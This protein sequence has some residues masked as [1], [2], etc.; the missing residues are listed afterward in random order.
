M[1]EVHTTKKPGDLVL[2]LRGDLF[3]VG[4]DGRQRPHEMP[5]RR[6]QRLAAEAFRERIG[7]VA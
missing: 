5:H 3:I 6:K 1:I 7:Y 2:S 4:E